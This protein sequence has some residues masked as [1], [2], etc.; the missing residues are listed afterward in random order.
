MNLVEVINIALFI[1]SKPTRVTTTDIEKGKYIYI[2]DQRL[3]VVLGLWAT[4]TS[5]E[6]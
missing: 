4:F 1:N 2:Y 6:S 5:Y 3:T